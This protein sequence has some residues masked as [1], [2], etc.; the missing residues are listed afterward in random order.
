MLR[1]SS[2]T[3]G[4]SEISINQLYFSVSTAEWMFLN[5]AYSEGRSFPLTQIA[6]QVIGCGQYGCTLQEDV[7][8]NL[9]L[10]QVREFAVR[11][12]VVQL[13]GN[14]GRRVVTIP[15]TF[16]KGFLDG[17]NLTLDAV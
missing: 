14:R 7:A 4:S 3:T 2:S 1:R 11:G 5:A 9:T 10:E 17:A 13:T 16:F 8:I 15:S 6:R 12:F